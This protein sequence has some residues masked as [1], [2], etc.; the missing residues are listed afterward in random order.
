MSV[1]MFRVTL[2]ARYFKE[3]SAQD[4]PVD[5]GSYIFRVAGSVV[6][7]TCFNA[8]TEPTGAHFPMIAAFMLQEPPL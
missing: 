8:I 1:G 5:A 2:S 4:D 3:E 7:L 6:K